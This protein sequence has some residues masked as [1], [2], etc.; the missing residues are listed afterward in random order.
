VSLGLPR[1]PPPGF[2]RDAAPP[3]GVGAGGGRAR[4]GGGG[5]G[6]GGRG[7]GGGVGEFLTGVLAWL[8]YNQTR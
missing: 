8:F 6:G 1:R 4:G 5:G 7:G 2:G 3:V